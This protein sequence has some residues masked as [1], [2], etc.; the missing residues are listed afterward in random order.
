MEGGKWMGSA[1]S[2]GWLCWAAE[3]VRL[4]ASV[5]AVPEP[6][7]SAG[8]DAYASTG[9]AAAMLPEGRKLAKG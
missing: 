5:V 7:Q 2:G 9:S 3:C 4:N 8:L 6:V 1:L